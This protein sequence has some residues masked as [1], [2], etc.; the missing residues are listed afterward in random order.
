[1]VDDSNFESCIENTLS[2]LKDKGFYF[3]FKGKTKGKFTSAVAWK[4]FGSWF[5]LLA[6][7]KASYFSS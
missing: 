3:Q 5:Y 6:L 1:M 2:S 4:G 7:V